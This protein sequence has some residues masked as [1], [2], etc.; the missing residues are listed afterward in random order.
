MERFW[1]LHPV[2]VGLFI[3][4][5][6]FG[7]LILLRGLE[8]GDFDWP[9]DNKTVLIGDGLLLPLYAALTS[10]LMRQDPK[11]KGRLYKDRRWH[12][13]VFLTGLALALIVEVMTV[14][15]GHWGL[16]REPTVSKTYH[17]F[18]FVA[19]F[20]LLVSAWPL[21]VWRRQQV[22]AAGVAVV[23]LGAFVTIA[24]WEIQ[25]MAHESAQ[26]TVQRLGDEF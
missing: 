18:I 22:L 20:Y 8:R 26:V 24:W 10:H 3:M 14:L 23:S 6:D 15:D 16:F 21:I 7:A 19:L 9:S 11:I 17:R 4:V 2:L 1:K 12:L 25:P 13:G 5:V